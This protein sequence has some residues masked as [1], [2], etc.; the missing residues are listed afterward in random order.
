MATFTNQATLT[1]GGGSVTSNTVTGQIVQALTA[2]KTAVSASYR[3]GDTVSYVIQLRNSG[4]SA[5]TGLTVTDNLGA[6]SFTPTSGAAVTLTPLTYRAG[7]VRYFQN[8][9]LQ[10]APTVTQT[11]ASVQFAGIG[12]PAGGVTTIAYEATVGPYADSALEGTIENTVTVTGTTLAEPVTA[13]ATLGANS[14]ALL[15]IVKSLSPE[16]ITGSGTLTYTFT[17][18][19]DGNVAADASAGIVL[20]D[21]FDPVLQNIS[22]FYNGAAWD[23]SNYTY[24]PA[25]GVFSTNAGAITVPAATVTQD[26]QTGLYTRTPGRV[27][28]Q[29]SGTV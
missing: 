5:L 9:V 25:T 10:A 20:T 15:R 2:E 24:A 22:V 8:G 6:Y 1:Y 27:T 17:I 3:V 18:E 4:A 16:Q 29:I 11:A 12:V 13:T 28:L 19:N 26:A 23:A 14:D 7:T 21:T